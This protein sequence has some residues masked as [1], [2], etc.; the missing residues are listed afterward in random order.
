M[1]LRREHGGG[2]QRGLSGDERET[3]DLEQHDDEDD[4]ESVVLDEVRHERHAT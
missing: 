4:P 2:D 1:P 3:G